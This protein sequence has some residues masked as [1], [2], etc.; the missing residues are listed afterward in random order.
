M[1]IPN[2]NIVCKCPK[3][4]FGERYLV[5]G[6]DSINDANRPGLVF[7]SKTVIMEWDDSM[8]ERISRFSRREIR[9]ECPSRHY[10]RW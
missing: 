8:T 2:K 4:R 1:W 3:V 9:G 6:K 5:L 10:E 7:N